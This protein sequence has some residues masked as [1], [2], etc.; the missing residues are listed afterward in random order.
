MRLNSEARHVLKSLWSRGRIVEGEQLIKCW[1]DF[2]RA[3]SPRTDTERSEALRVFG[4]AVKQAQRKQRGHRTIGRQPEPL[5]RTFH[6]EVERAIKACLTERPHTHPSQHAVAR[7][8]AHARGIDT[9]AD[10]FDEYNAERTLRRQLNRH[11]IEWDAIVER[12]W[13]QWFFDVQLSA[14]N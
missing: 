4:Q 1:K 5:R 12:A 14:S 9:T 11:L 2:E 7:K 10:E 3:V 6:S 8:L 13:L